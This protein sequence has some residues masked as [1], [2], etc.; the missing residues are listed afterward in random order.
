M[1]AHVTLYA[2]ND[3]LSAILEGVDVAA[4]V[5]CEWYPNSW[6]PVISPVGCPQGL[7]DPMHGLPKPCS[8]IKCKGLSDWGRLGKFW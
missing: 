4:S 7:D 5:R 1:K 6:L 2:S 8:Q 3:K